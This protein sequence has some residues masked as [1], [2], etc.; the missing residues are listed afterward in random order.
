MQFSVIEKSF[1][2]KTQRH[3]CLCV[4]REGH[5]LPYGSEPPG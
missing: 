3:A 2:D 1:S 5:T 4:V